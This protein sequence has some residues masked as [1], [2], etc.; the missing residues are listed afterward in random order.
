MALEHNVKTMQ[1]NGTG[2]GLQ[3]PRD[4]LRSIDMFADLDD[5]EL[6]VLGSSMRS[7]EIEAGSVLFREGDKG[8]ELFVVK[9]GA[10]SISVK[11]PDEQELVISEIQEGNF[12]GE[13]SI[14]EGAPRSA[15]CR[16]KMKSTLFGLKSGD[17]YELIRSH[18][19]TASKIMYRMLAITV[20]RL[21]N[22][23]NF[24][25][26]MV[27][28]GEDARKRAVTDDFTGLFNRRF[29][30][31]ALE[32]RFREAK[33]KG[34][35][36]CL[37]MVDL[38]HFGSLNKEYGEQ[39]GNAVILEA[40]SVFKTVFGTKDILIRYGGDEFTFVLPETTSSE[41]LEKCETVCSGLRKLSILEPF[42]GTIRRV[43]SSIGVAAYPEHARTVKELLEK[44][45]GALYKA[46]ESGRDR[47]MPA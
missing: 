33:M 38:D 15:T 9:E 25:T 41:A 34:S 35:S 26:D 8:D 28:W 20:E 45:D 4:F 18:P 7:I 5:P 40:V 3:T 42:G 27:Q 13:M 43:T 1:K 44:A 22:T 12:F 19:R 6:A 37:A 24:L 32:E 31:D 46:K 47:A 39:V 21:R 29:L 36:L 10:V 2:D 16:T 30:D 23:G 14:F 17:F 11:L